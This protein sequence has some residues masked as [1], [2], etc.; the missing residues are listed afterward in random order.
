MHC[1]NIKVDLL[2]KLL[3]S[4]TYSQKMAKYKKLSLV[5]ENVNEERFIREVKFVKERERLKLS[6]SL[7]EFI[8]KSNSQHS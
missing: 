8:S 3:K 6:K 1:Q 2:P 7:K 5:H 4:D